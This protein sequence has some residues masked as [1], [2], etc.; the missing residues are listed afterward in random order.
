MNTN[1]ITRVENGL[2]L[3]AD[4]QRKEVIDTIKQTVARG[5]TDAQ[6]QMFLVLASRYNL[7]PFLCEIWCAQIGG[8]MTVLTSRDGYL[9]I[10]Q[11]DPNFDGIVS[12]TCARTISSKSIQSPRR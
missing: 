7:D 11:R 9:K 1:G 4:L 5:A 10:A 2:S 12:A 3:Q 8:Q 6:L